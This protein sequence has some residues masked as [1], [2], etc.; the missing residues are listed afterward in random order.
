MRRALIHLF[1]S[2]VMTFALSPVFGAPVDDASK[3]ILKESELFKDDTIK[4]K[5]AE[6]KKKPE[7]KTIIQPKKVEMESEESAKSSDP[8]KPKGK[9]KNNNSNDISIE[10]IQ[11][12]ETDS[13]R[14]TKKR[15][16]VKKETQK[17]VEPKPKKADKS[18]P[19]PVVK[20]DS[21]RD[22]EE[23][24]G[25]TIGTLDAEP[26]KKPVKKAKPVVKKEEPKKLEP[27]PKKA[28]KPKPKPVVKRDSR[29]DEEEDTGSTIGTLDTEPEKKPVKK[30][31]PVVKKEEPK[32]LEPKPK[33][34][35][36]PK[37]K[38]VVKR[39]SRRD[40]EEDTGS[41][42]GTLDTEPAKKPVKKA[43]PVVKKEEPK[44]VEPKPK[45]ADKP[46]P[47][48][49]RD[50]RRD[51]EEDTGLSIGTID[52]ETT[53]KPV[54][55]PK[56]VRVKEEPKPIVKKEEPKKVEPKPKKADKPK[57]KPVVKRGSRR[58]EEEGTGLSIGT[59]DT[60][61]TEKPVKKPRP[62][63]VK[64]E[65]KPVKK[66]PV[67]VKEEPK[68]IK[69]KTDV[70]VVDTTPKKKAP[71]KTTEKK[72]ERTGVAATLENTFRMLKVGDAKKSA[73]AVTGMKVYPG[74][75]IQTLTDSKGLLKLTDNSKMYL[76]EFTKLF[77]FNGFSDKLPIRSY[78][79]KGRVRIIG[80]GESLIEIGNQKIKTTKGKYDYVID[81]FIP[82]SPV[83]FVL[84]G[85]VTVYQDQWGTRKDQVTDG[86]K[87][88]LADNSYKAKAIPVKKETLEFLKG[89]L[90][91][92]FD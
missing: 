21:R 76:D 34:A 61:T 90:I 57:P 92:T 65:P 24:T 28:D 47:V 87:F 14:T 64:E 39:D 16:V 67:A 91:K 17:K 83:L 80:E 54:K 60:E 5:P 7:K 26:E 29:R 38:P 55:K 4:E 37:P 63:R 71:E 11:T 74:E 8:P 45:K 75:Y 3:G 58:D 59:I 48:V 85:K 18:K 42:I 86:M 12:E 53:E 66:E 49:K 10:L 33:K 78:L 73:N 41:S 79:A 2:I 84:S 15:P 25:F 9:E 40:E 51:E 69:P 50:S 82:S 62:V 52:T 88:N 27:K 30:A 56:P 20:R 68:E 77:L 70:A 36:K 44:K 19:K 23:D 81:N 72:P 31:K 6:K 35:D 13:R 22:E 1:I 32:K 43:K 89:H 46:K